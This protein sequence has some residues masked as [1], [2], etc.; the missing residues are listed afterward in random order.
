MKPSRASLFYIFSLIVLGV[1]AALVLF[2]PLV[3]GQEYSTVQKEQLLKTKDGWIIQF[4]LVNQE[5]K[6]TRY[7]ISFTV[8]EGTPY[9]EKILV[10]VAGIYTYTHHIGAE[11]INQGKVQMIIYRDEETTPLEKTVY[12][13]R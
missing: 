10:P 3:I 6:D 8:D 11:R 4:N 12:Y 5:Q 2:R 7:R 1:L 9:E 13:L